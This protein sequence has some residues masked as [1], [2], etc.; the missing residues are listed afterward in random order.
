MKRKHALIICLAVVL[1][2]PSLYLAPPVIRGDI[3]PLAVLS[4]SMEPM[5]NVGDL[6]FVSKVNPDDVEPGDIIAFN[7]PSGRKNVLITHRVIA[8]DG[9][10]GGFK[11]KGDACEDPDPF[12]VKQ[13]DVVGKPAFLVPFIGYLFGPKGSKNPLIWFLL[14]MLPAG[15][16]IADEIKNILTPPSQARKKEK[17]ERRKKRKAIKVVH[18]KRFLMIFLFSTIVFGA[19]SLPSLAGSGYVTDINVGTLKIE[20]REALPGVCTFAILNNPQGEISILPGY[21]VLPPKSDREVE[22][23]RSAH[24]TATGVSGLEHE[25][26]LITVS[27]SPYIMPVFWIYTLAKKNPYLPGLVS[28]TIPPVILTLMLSPIWF[29]RRVKYKY[30]PRRHI[31]KKMKRRLLIATF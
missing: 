13:E 29:Q 5:M 8:I 6:I 3:I 15:L 14:V 17:E 16:I 20:N 4:G 21:A 23:M 9:E 18:Y 30:K 28:S 19:V 10:S 24:E 7:D 31:F 2:L 11:T 25:D 12:V 1:A 22:I 26:A 27:K